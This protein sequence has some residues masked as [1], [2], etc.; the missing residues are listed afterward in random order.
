MIIKSCIDKI[1]KL[2][3]MLSECNFLQ[4]KKKKRIKK[5]ILI[6]RMKIKDVLK[7]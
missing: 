4:F 2:E 7:S 5:N 1:F 3:K 6:C